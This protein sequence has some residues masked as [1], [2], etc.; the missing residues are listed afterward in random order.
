MLRE[1][2]QLL[3]GAPLKFRKEAEAKLREV[4]DEYE[5]WL[6]CGQP[7]LECYELIKFARQ[8]DLRVGRKFQ[9]TIRRYL[10][11]TE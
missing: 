1:L 4:V 8:P 5:D 3:E 11:N 9:Q 7:N 6:A 2:V 10:K